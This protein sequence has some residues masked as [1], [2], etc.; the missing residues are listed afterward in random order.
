LDGLSASSTIATAS[1]SISTQARKVR[2]GRVTAPKDEPSPAPMMPKTIPSPART[3]STIRAQLWPFHANQT[4]SAKT[5]VKTTPRTSPNVPNDSPTDAAI[6]A[7]SGD[8]PDCV[9]A[10]SV[11]VSRL[12]TLI[13]WAT[14]LSTIDPTKAPMPAR[15]VRGRSTGVGAP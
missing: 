8:R 12:S 13:T 1:K 3:H 14:R 7:S 6:S 9:V 15:T 11:S 2:T 5:P 10:S 4:N